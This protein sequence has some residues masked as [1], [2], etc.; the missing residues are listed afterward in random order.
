MHVLLVLT[1]S[2][3]CESLGPFKCKPGSLL[4]KPH[5]TPL[6]PPSL[7]QTESRASPSYRS[8]WS[9]KL[10]LR[11]SFEDILPVSSPS[12]WLPNLRRFTDLNERVDN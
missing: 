3:G 8:V 2:S 5:K 7:F 11:G 1:E 4:S 6:L 9:L 10:L 12:I